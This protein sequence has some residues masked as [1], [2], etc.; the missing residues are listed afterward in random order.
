[1]AV[2]DP[3]QWL[4]KH[5]EKVV[6]VA[7][8]G[9]LCW[10][11]YAYP[12]WAAKNPLVDAINRNVKGIQD[13]QKVEYT[14]DAETKD[15]NKKVP[16]GINPVQ[17]YVAVVEKTVGQPW[18][19]A[20]EVTP[21]DSR[22]VIFED[23]IGGHWT[24]VAPAPVGVEAPT[25]VLAKAEKN[26]V[27]VIFKIDDRVQQRACEES[28]VREY[29]KGLPFYQV[30]ITRESVSG[31]EAPVEL[32]KGVNW[33][34]TGLGKRYG[35]P[36]EAVGGG[37][38]LDGPGPWHMEE[39]VVVFSQ[40]ARPPDVGDEQRREEERRRVEEELRRQQEQ[41]K[42]RRDAE[43]TG[44]KP[45]VGTGTT[46]GPKPITGGPKPPKTVTPGTEERYYWFVDND[47]ETEGKYKYTVTIVVKNPVYKS[48]AYTDSDKVPPL[49]SSTAAVSNVVEIAPFK[50][51]YFTGGVPATEQ[52]MCVVR[53][54]TAQERKLDNAAVLALVAQIKQGETGATGTEPA[55]EWVKERFSVKP[56]EEV[57]V[58]KST[59]LADGQAVDVDFATGGEVI[60]M[61]QGF[62]VSEGEQNKLIQ[63][64]DGTLQRVKVV[65]R[66]VVPRLEIT[67]MDRKG[68]VYRK[69]QETVK[70]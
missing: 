5:V 61:S 22:W 26:R 68:N 42:K 38:L 34:P 2:M 28:R 62:Q 23:D 30:I 35:E 41:E 13:R 9:V 54:L 33:L 48:P 64:P 52:A 19:D 60:L 45:P 21:Y 1:M 58:V 55:G 27:I 25:Q 20:N 29:G 10:S 40:R 57:G 53:V 24:P 49:L 4:L 14:A 50:E 59:K 70:D 47:V 43:K 63:A 7:A 65:T 37:A 17:D 11:L 15:P 3:K 46:P 36:A 56:G 67:V 16:P 31:H 18:S 69:W 51:W 8:L 39:G 66:T 32:N 12:P 44:V 6:L